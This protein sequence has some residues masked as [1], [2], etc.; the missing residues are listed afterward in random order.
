MI[1]LLALAALA[2]PTVD[3]PPRVGVESEVRLVDDLSRPV[4]GAPVRAVTR[5]GLPGE[6]E[7]AIGLTDGSG[8]VWWSPAEPGPT[9]V[10]VRD[11]EL[12]VRVEGGGPPATAAV[13]LGGLLAFALAMIVA[14]AISARRRTR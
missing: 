2:N 10:R 3:P 13:M 1:A 12:I 7:L 11:R 5:I 8:A 14:G 4:V 9:R 6:R